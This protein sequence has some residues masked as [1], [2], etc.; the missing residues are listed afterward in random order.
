VQA[1]AVHQLTLE[2]TV[3]LTDVDRAIF[4]D[5]YTATHDQ[6]SCMNTKIE[7]SKY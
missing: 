3:K 5:A 6:T 2:L 1:L 7:P 4:V